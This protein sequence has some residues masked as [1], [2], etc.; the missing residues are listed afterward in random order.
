MIVSIQDI[1]GSSIVSV[2]V[3]SAATVTVSYL[4]QPPS[5]PPQSLILFPSFVFAFVFVSQ[6]FP[7]VKYPEYRTDSAV[8][9]TAATSGPSSRC[10]VEEADPLELRKEKELMEGRWGDA[11][12]G[13]Q[14]IRGV[15]GATNT[16][17]ELDEENL[18]DVTG[19][20][21]PARLCRY[22]CDR[23]GPGAKPD[24]DKRERDES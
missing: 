23:I 19:N 9:Q 16:A 2:Q 17:G 3:C 14:G 22:S 6:S 7:S 13:E 11:G 21:S 5:P 20:W 15:M 4:I 12:P 1:I 24:V 10:R 18:I 8:R